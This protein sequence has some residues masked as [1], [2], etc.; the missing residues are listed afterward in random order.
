MGYR[1]IHTCF[2][3]GTGGSGKNQQG[4]GIEIQLNLP[5]LVPTVLSSLNYEQRGQEG[6]GH[7]PDGLS[8]NP[9]NPHVFKSGK[10]T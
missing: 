6:R 3:T 5:R 8:S 4:T 1:D 9:Q 2:G 7:K 10:S